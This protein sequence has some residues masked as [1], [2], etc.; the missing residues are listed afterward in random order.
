MKLPEG[1]VLMKREKVCAMEIWVECLNGEAK[2]MSRKDS[3]EI[4]AIL[5]SATG[6]RRNKSKRRYGPH[7]IQRGFERVQRDVDSM[8]L[9]GTM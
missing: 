2:Y 6:W 8:K 3:M 5:A 9:G 4:N 7:G 1:E